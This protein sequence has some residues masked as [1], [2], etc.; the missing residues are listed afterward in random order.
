[1]LLKNKQVAG[2][3]FKSKIY[4]KIFKKFS[5]SMQPLSKCGVI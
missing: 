5:L 1:M 4:F 2:F 3:F